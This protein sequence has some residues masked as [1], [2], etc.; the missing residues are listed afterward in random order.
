MK[1]DIS[2]Y[3]WVIFTLLS[4][5]HMLMAMFFYIWGPLAPALKNTL[6]LTNSQ[7]GLVISAMYLSMVTISI[8]SGILT[9]RY[10]AKTMLVISVSL[11][12]T[13]LLILYFFPIYDGLFAASIIGGTGY[14]MINQVTTKGLMYWFEPD[15]RATIMGIKQIGVT[16]GGALTALYIPYVSL[17]FDWH[18]G[19]LLLSAVILIMAIASYLFYQE[20]PENFT[21]TLPGKKN[22]V[23]VTENLRSMIL[24][25]ILIT[26]TIIFTF[27]A[28]SQACLVSF[29]VI[30]TQETFHL[31]KVVA[32]SFLTVAM[33]AGTAS[34][35]VFGVI[36]DRLFGSDRVTPLAVL[37]LIGMISSSAFI[38][39]N[40][41]NAPL[42]FLFLISIFLG[43]ALIG[44]NSLAIT[45]I[46]EVAGHEMV[47]SV[48]GFL[49]T[50]A[51]GGM[52]IAPSVFGAIVDWKGYEAAWCMVAIFCGIS[53]F[54]YV[55]VLSH[56]RKKWITR[57]L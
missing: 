30:Y 27:L 7:L 10:G 12:G 5:S 8:P 16:I 40:D 34:R 46:A 47:G 6:A 2:S 31:N 33:M 18:I 11:V 42:W 29:I 28:A 24:K 20:K 51:W 13:G 52:V 1:K 23:S 55:L 38:L 56:Q 3:Q 9:D 49:L 32:G 54:G 26:L 44:W 57:S 14:G 36:S 41:N 25:P 4:L 53:F 43:A 48:M 35:V 39:V 50:I 45:L 21:K 22:T 37:A 19:I 17:F 15:R